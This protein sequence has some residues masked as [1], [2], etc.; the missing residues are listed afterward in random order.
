MEIKTDT[1]KSPLNNSGTT[2]FPDSLIGSIRKNTKLLIILIIFLV[3]Y[4]LSITALYFFKLNASPFLNT[5]PVRN[6]TS[7]V[8]PASTTKP[9]SV[10]QSNEIPNFSMVRIYPSLDRHFSFYI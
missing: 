7:S 9:Q 6:T 2:S 4:A 8:S 1:D 5:L 10:Q 3:I